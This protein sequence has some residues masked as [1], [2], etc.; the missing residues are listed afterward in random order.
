MR[1]S[2]DTLVKLWPLFL[3][4]GILIAAAAEVRMAVADNE[5]D[6]KAVEKQQ[7]QVQEALTEQAAVNARID[8]RT[9]TMKEQLEV[10][11][12]EL[13]EQR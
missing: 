9:K 13:R 2:V 3:C 4:A 10:I 12:Q 8:E 5:E 7:Q 1:N 6:I 11:L